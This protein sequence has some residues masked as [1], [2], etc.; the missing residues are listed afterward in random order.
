MSSKSRF[1]KFRRNSYV[2]VS[3]GEPDEETGERPTVRLYPTT[4]HM[5]GRMRDI[6]VDLARL[7]GKLQTANAGKTL[8]SEIQDE[9]LT[10]SGGTM[11]KRAIKPVPSAEVLA[12]SEATGQNWSEIAL[13]LMDE[14]NQLTICELILDS[15]RDMLEASD[16]DPDTL[17][18]RP[19]IVSDFYANV[20]LRTLFE[21]LTGWFEANAGEVGNLGKKVTDRLKATVENAVADPAPPTMTEEGEILDGPGSKTTNSGEESS[22]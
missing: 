11:E 14:S 2:D 15:A 3:Y 17:R 1:R 20:D 13:T 19:E 4:A 7:L 6:A 16:R 8:Q 5:A 10:D 22:S 18:I 12:M 21:L 9:K